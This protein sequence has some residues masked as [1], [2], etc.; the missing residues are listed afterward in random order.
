VTGCPMN[1]VDEFRHRPVNELAALLLDKQAA[2]PAI[3]ERPGHPGGRDPNLQTADVDISTVRVLH[4]EEGAD[5][6]DP[7]GADHGFATRIIRWP[8]TRGYVPCGRSRATWTSGRPRPQLG[9][10]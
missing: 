2:D 9:S 5:T 4:G 8:R 6:L 10:S 1:N 7:T 3:K